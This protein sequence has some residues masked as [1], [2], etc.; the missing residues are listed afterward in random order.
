[1]MHATHLTGCSPTP[2]AHYLKA[3]GI[4][5][6]VAEQKDENACGYW[7][8]EHFVLE[9]ELDDERLMDFFQHDYRPTPILSPWAGRAGYLEG[10]EA[11]ESTRGGAILLRKFRE[12]A[13][14]RLADYRR[15]I[16][17][18]DTFQEFKKMNEVR[19]E[20]KL[21]DKLKKKQ[22]DRGESLPDELECWLKWATQ[23]EEFI[24][25]NLF[26]L[27]RNKLADDLLSWLD[28]AVA[29]GSD[30]AFAP[31]LG[32]SGGQEG[33]MDLG[34]NFMNNLL[35]LFTLNVESGK[36]SHE[37]HHWLNHALYG[38]P[39]RLM[40]ANTAGSLYPGRIGG[41]NSTSG[42]SRDLSINPWD[43][44]LMLEGALV[45]R[46]S[47]T[48]KLE[49]STGSNLGYPFTV[50]PTSVGAGAI[51]VGD[52]KKTRSGKSE[53]WAPLWARAMSHYEVLAFFREGSLSLGRK[54]PTNGL[55]MAR[56]VAR[57]GMDRGVA[58]FQRFIFFK[59]SGDNDLA[60]PLSRIAASRTVA[61]DLIVDL[62]QRGF[63]EKLRRV[64][65]DKDVPNSLKGVIA[66]FENSL[67]ALT[68]SGR[69]KQTV[70]KS[71]ILLGEVMLALAKSGKG[72]KAVSTLPRLSEGWVLQADDGSH[73][74]RIAAALAGMWSK[75]LPMRVNL[76][77][78]DADGKTWIKT[79]D[80]RRS[81]C[82]WGQ[83]ALERNLLAVLRRRLIEA[84]RRGLARKPFYSPLQADSTAVAAFLRRETDDGRIARLLVA[85]S[86][87]EM[88]DAL[89]KWEVE[90]DDDLPAAYSILK[91][92]FVDDSTLNWMNLL[93]EGRNLPLS[94]TIPNLLGAGRIDEA[95]RTAWRRQ[96]ASG[97]YLPRGAVP[98]VS[99]GIDGL[100]L[101]AALMIPLPVSDLNRL[102]AHLSREEREKITG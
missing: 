24:K 77:P 28:A 20:K 61:V 17:A 95:V 26:I 67:F 39:A 54:H 91:P 85:L 23:K 34:V 60:V 79:N 22:K 62:D 98:S 8:G 13:A 25:N 12:S 97:M 14:S 18:L 9:S 92:L 90:T 35:V 1:M 82:V 59:R 76:L 37:S 74:F 52:E 38:T 29:I 2:L 15:L 46:P 83:G 56:C 93:P 87:A 42:F 3:L 70:Q 49:S 31:L 69:G 7:Q 32:G 53:I 11:E 6:L 51:T 99:V 88:P 81:L 63:L 4:L 71:L 100:R 50:E 73:E 57:L 40:V 65:R 47:L 44:V 43:Y 16:N 58:S 80:A 86:F 78:V 84:E 10:E 101:A 94:Q 41:P 27:L 72:Q 102:F 66:Q 64:A 21:L 33:S 55:D 45:F 96:R 68:G 30:R 5:R 89:P 19:A 75:G 36:P 48:R